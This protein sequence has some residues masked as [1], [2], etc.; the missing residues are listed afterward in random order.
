MFPPA[1]IPAGMESGIDSG[2]DSGGD[3]EAL[4]PLD[5]NAPSGCLSARFEL[6]AECLPERVAICA[7]G[8]TW[9]YAEV[10]SESNRIAAA[11]LDRV[12]PGE[13]CI[14][15]LFEQGA[16]LIIAI[17]AVLKAGKAYFALQPEWQCH[18]QAGLKRTLPHWKLLARLEASHGMRVLPEE[19]YRFD[20]IRQLAGHLD[21]F[22]L[23]TSAERAAALRNKWSAFSRL[24]RAYFTLSQQDG[25]EKVH[26]IDAYRTRS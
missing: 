9:S 1:E 23:S 7:D 20:S 19:I 18:F 11:I 5:H 8:R 3:A 10:N 25:W 2:T 6:V 24:R 14:A 12:S 21:Y 4:P 16:P 15:L 17:L 22:V 26:E 13:G